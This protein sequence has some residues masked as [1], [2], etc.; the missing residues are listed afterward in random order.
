VYDGIYF[1]DAEIGSRAAVRFFSFGTGRISHVM[2]LAESPIGDW[3]GL[4][5]SPDGGW[6]R[7]SQVDSRSGD[8]M[9][10]DNFH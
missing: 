5:I 3:P 6:L 7:Y 8:I 10:V 2:T 4:V 9:L 1:V